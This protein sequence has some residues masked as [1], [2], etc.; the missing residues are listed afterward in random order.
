MTANTVTAALI[1]KY[2]DEIYQADRENMKEWT[3]LKILNAVLPQ[4]IEFD[5]AASPAFRVK[6]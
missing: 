4:E 2:M 3:V 6:E 1:A 5:P